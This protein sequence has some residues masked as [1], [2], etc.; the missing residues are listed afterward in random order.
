M[1][2]A[3]MMFLLSGIL[4]LKPELNTRAFTQNFYNEAIDFLFKF[5][6]LT[7]PRIS[8]RTYKIFVF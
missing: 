4:F 5:M 3:S 2:D 8:E 1:G 6:D 7:I